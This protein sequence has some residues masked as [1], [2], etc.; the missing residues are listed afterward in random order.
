MLA[1]SSNTMQTH[2]GHEFMLLHV[3]L[4]FIAKQASTLKPA[5]KDKQ[6]AA[7]VTVATAL[8]REYGPRLAPHCDR[9]LGAVLAPLRDPLLCAELIQ[10]LASDATVLSVFLPRLLRSLLTYDTPFLVTTTDMCIG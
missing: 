9:F 2:S 4:A 3:S 1:A 8:V 6:R 10:A 5:A 7:A